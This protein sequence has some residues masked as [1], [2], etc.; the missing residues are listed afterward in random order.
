LVKVLFLYP[1]KEFWNKNKTPKERL[2]TLITH[3]K[4]QRPDIKWDFY[5]CPNLDETGEE[6]PIQRLLLYSKHLESV[7][8]M[9]LGY[10]WE[11][12]STIR[13]VRRM[14]EALHNIEVITEFN[15]EDKITFSRE[16]LFD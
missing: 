16:E 9:F 2:D 10:G 3:F 13:M 15:K 14:A 6:T 4:R 1:P 5:S 12:D 8:Y 7:S 11:E